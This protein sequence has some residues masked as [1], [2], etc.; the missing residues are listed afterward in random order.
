MGTF[1]IVN[2]N[3]I[4]SL[5][6]IDVIVPSNVPDVWEFGPFGSVF[7]PGRQWHQMAPNPNLK[8]MHYL[9]SQPESFD[10]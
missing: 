8:C 2:I 10:Y 3:Y 7:V 9:V 1:F 6:Y 5:A 4:F